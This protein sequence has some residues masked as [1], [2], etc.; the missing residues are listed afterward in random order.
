MQQQTKTKQSEL[1]NI[2]QNTQEREVNS[3]SLIVNE[4]IDGTPFRIIGD[5]ERGYALTIGPYIITP[6]ATR[7]ETTER[8]TKPDYNTIINLITLITDTAMKKLEKSK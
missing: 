5:E 3:N 7:E 2:Q 6:W 4:I 8:A 1:L